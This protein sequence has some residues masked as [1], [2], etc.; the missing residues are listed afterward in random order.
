[1]SVPGTKDDSN[2]ATFERL[3]N[4]LYADQEAEEGKE[5]EDTEKC[6]ESDE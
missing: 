1:M 2:G 6:E 3:I 5:K 4:N